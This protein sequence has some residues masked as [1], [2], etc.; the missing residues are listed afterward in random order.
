MHQPSY[1]QGFTLIELMVVVVIIGILASIAYP[2][3]QDY[4][5]SAQRTDAKS[6]IMDA[7]QKLERCYTENGKYTG[8][9][10]TASSGT[11]FNSDEE[12]FSITPTITASSFT[13]VATRIAGIDDKCHKFTYTSSNDK[14]STHKDGSDTTTT[15]NCW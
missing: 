14:K 10:T 6:A 5:A 15:A 7:A 12:F 2:A 4:I 3:Y 9:T 11:A 13:L 8:C 1:N